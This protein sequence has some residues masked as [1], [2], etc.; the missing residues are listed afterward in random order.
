MNEREDRMKPKKE[1]KLWV[2]IAM[3][4]LPEIVIIVSLFFVAQKI[5][6]PQLI[7]EIHHNNEQSKLEVFYE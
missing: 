7:I 2:K 6:K 3:L 1:L 5:D 4:L